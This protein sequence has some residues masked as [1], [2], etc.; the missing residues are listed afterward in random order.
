MLLDL[1]RLSGP[2]WGDNR[3]TRPV[4][5]AQM[6]RLIAAMT[7][8]VCMLVFCSCGTVALSGTESLLVAPKLNKRQEEVSKALDAT[9]S[10][11]SIVYKYPRSGEYRSPFIFF[12]F[13]GDERDEAI[14]F[15][16]YANEAAG[17]VRAKILGEQESGAWSPLYDI[18]SQSA[19]VEFVQFEK[20]LDTNSYCMVIGWQGDGR[21][22]STLEI[23]SLRDGAFPLE[24]SCPYLHY[25]IRDF[26]GDGLAEAVV[27]SRDGSRGGFR[28]SLLR[29]RGSRIETAGSLELASETE[30]V[31]AL[32]TGELW[33]DGSAVYIDE[34]L[35]GGSVVT[36]AS[37]IIRVSDGGLELLC[38]GDEQ[39]SPERVNYE[40]TFRVEDLLCTDFDSD[41]F[42]EVPHPVDLPGALESADTD[43]PRLVQFMRLTA[44]G[45]DIQ[46]SAVINWQAGYFV[47][48]PDRWKD[49]VMVERKLENDEWSFR[50]WNPNTRE[51]AEELLRVRVTYGRD[52][53]DMFEDY[54]PLAA[55]GATSYAAYIPKLPGESLAVVEP[56][57]RRLFRL[58]PS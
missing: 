54:T 15:Y 21:Q 25:S 57:V 23:Y 6:I 22:S 33:N 35:T 29:R 50:K 7:A 36:I 43:V 34:M 1:K 58:L 2:S 10:L 4:A 46:S 20:L 17:T 14:V 55:K 56:E 9:L 27:I 51:P 19:G 45:F 32:T 42:I 49:Q 37:E 38:G 26:N 11:R 41:G 53:V 48:F 40:L 31:L 52:Y 24:A 30:S 47:Y 8:V 16:S 18:T 5:V 3:R 13:D 39:G 28:V 44:A 12:D